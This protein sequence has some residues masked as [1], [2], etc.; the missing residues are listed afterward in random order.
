MVLSKAANT[1]VRAYIF[2][3]V[4]PAGIAPMILTMQA[5][6]FSANLV[7]SVRFA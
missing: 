7:N 5:W 2:V 4:A 1:V 3:A 6:S